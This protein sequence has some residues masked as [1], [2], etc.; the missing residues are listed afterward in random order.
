MTERKK[1]LKIFEGE[2]LT[3]FF[4]TSPKKR[5]H[6]A[7]LNLPPSVSIE[8]RGA[9][10]REITE[11]PSIAPS[12]VINRMADRML[13]LR[14]AEFPFLSFHTWNLVLDTL[15]GRTEI[16]R[17]ELSDLIVGIADECGIID[18]EI[19]RDTD[20]T[21][22]APNP[23][24]SAFDELLSLSPVKVLLVQQFCEFFWGGGT[25]HSMTFDQLLGYFF[26][27]YSG[28]CLKNNDEYDFREHW[29]EPQRV[30]CKNSDTLAIRIKHK[31]GQQYLI[32]YQ[33]NPPLLTYQ[34]DGEIALA[35]DHGRIAQEIMVIAEQVFYKD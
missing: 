31:S 24:Q 29:N 18:S 20:P 30:S 11:N 6:M 12:V 1:P 33:N 22:R 17:S 23:Y 7:A 3:N 8:E 13:W 19:T 2:P 35:L 4:S 16:D 26:K 9:K 14:Q 15:N 28:H 34:K 10:L 32:N 25:D 21:D 27:R 5:D